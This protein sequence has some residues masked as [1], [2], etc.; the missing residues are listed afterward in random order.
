[1]ISVRNGR[2][3]KTQTNI[4]QSRRCRTQRRRITSFQLEAE[5]YGWIELRMPSIVI[6]PPGV[7]KTWAAK[8]AAI[9]AKAAGL[10]KTF[11]IVTG[12]KDLTPDALF[13]ERLVVTDA[14][15][16]FVRLLPSMV[17]KHC[18]GKLLPVDQY[19]SSDVRKLWKPEDWL[20][21]ILDESTRCTP[22]FIDAC[23]PLLNDF[24]VTVENETFYAPVLVILLGNPAGMDATTTAFTHALTSRL[25][26]RITITQ[27]G[28]EELAMVFTLPGVRT[29]A[30]EFGFPARCRPSED[31]VRLACGVITILWGLPLDRRGMSSLSPEALDLIARVERA[32]PALAHKLTEVGELIHFGPDP[33]KGRR[34]V[35]SAMRRAHIEGASFDLGHLIDTCINCLSIGGKPTFSEGQEPNKQ[36]LLEDLIFE[37][38]EHVL[39]SA[40]LQ[41][42]ILE[43]GR[44]ENDDRH[45]PAELA[46]TVASALLAD[47]EGRVPRFERMI[48]DHDRRLDADGVIDREMRKRHFGEFLLRSARIDA[49]LAGPEKDSAAQALA[50][51]ADS[52]VVG[53]DGFVARADYAFLEELRGGRTL[54]ERGSAMVGILTDLDGRAV[55]LAL[56]EEVRLAVGRHPSS[57]P[58]RTEISDHVRRNQDFRMR[59]ELVADTV[60]G[61]VELETGADIGPVL[62]RLWAAF[63]PASPESVAAIRDFFAALFRAMSRQARPPYQERFEQIARSLEAT[64]GLA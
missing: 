31:H 23:L 15:E 2:R 36:S 25:F 49:N 51:R 43:H 58:F 6:G 17:R 9:K 20:V 10:I 39:T 40:S 46:K 50:R 19:R 22:A 26:E 14:A 62:K 24:Q 44:K 5:I 52:L 4:G 33:R 27:P 47:G 12:C 56:E 53:P 64:H 3:H 1:M 48:R 30:E 61:A 41:R 54:T 18:E 7:G 55:P 21:I 32:D 63:A 57:V 59:V 34:W 11:E 8:E 37:V 60:A 35:T 28:M 13:A 29:D 45:E 38:T 42:L 16:K